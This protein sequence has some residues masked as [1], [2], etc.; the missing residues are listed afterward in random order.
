M[1]HIADWK[2]DWEG[3]CVGRNAINDLQKIRY[4]IRPLFPRKNVQKQED[5]K[6]KIG[7]ELATVGAAFYADPRL[8]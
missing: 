2:L 1:I 8:N 3:H 5:F 4:H 7:P 6:T